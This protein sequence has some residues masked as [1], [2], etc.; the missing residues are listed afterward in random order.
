MEGG[1]GEEEL[2]DFFFG[3][4]EIRKEGERSFGGGWN[5]GVVCE[6]ELEVLEFGWVFEWDRD[7]RGF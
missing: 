5:E 4:G 1:K 2:G 6:V 3:E 7:E